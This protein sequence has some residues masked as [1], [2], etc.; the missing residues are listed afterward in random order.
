MKK[1]KPVARLSKIFG[2]VTS[3]HS[4]RA[5]RLQVVSAHTGSARR[6]Q[7]GNNYRLKSGPRCAHG[8]RAREIPPI[9]YVILSGDI[10]RL[11]GYVP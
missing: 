1:I 11:F 6:V 2:E 5:G 3:P 4:F 10:L 8:L 7:S 9:H